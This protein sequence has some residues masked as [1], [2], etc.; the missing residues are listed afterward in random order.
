MYCG[1][2]RRGLGLIVLRETNEAFKFNLPAAEAEGG[3]EAK[4]DLVG[5]PK[6][7]ASYTKRRT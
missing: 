2:G 5:K 4:S 6:C 7:T 3:V 1:S